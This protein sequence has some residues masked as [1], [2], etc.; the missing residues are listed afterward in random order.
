M[1]IYKQNGYSLLGYRTAD[2]EVVSSYGWESPAGGGDFVYNYVVNGVTKTS[3]VE[4]VAIGLDVDD[5]SYRTADLMGNDIINLQF[6]LPEFREFPTGCF[7]VFEGRTY[8]LFTTPEITRQHNRQFDYVMPMYTADYLLHLTLMRNV[9]TNYTTGVVDGDFRL[10]FTLTSYPAEHLQMIADCLNQVDSGWTVTVNADVENKEKLVPYEFIYCDEALRSIAEAYDTEYEFVGKN[11]ILGKVEHNKNTPLSMS[12]GRGNGFKSGVTRRNESDKPPVDRLYIQGGEQNIPENY[13]RTPI[14][15]DENNKMTYRG[16]ASNLLLLPRL[17]TNLDNSGCPTAN[18]EYKGVACI[19]DGSSFYFILNPTVVTD[20]TTHER[21]IRAKDLSDTGEGGRMHIPDVIYDSNGNAIDYFL[22]VPSQCFLVSDDGRSVERVRYANHSDEVHNGLDP[23][24]RPRTTKVEAVYDASEV[25]PMRVGGVSKAQA[26]S[27][28]TDDD[29]NSITFYDIYDAAPDCPNY[30]D[31]SIQT[32]TMTIIFQDGMLAGR[33]FDLN[34]YDSGQYKDLPVCE[35]TTVNGVACKRLELCQAEQDGMPM[36]GGVFIPRYGDHYIIFHCSLPKEYIGSSVGDSS[37]H[38]NGAQ[39]IAYGA[40]FRALREAV[41]YLYHHGKATF[42]FSGSVDTMWV[43]KKWDEYVE[44]YTDVN[45]PHSTY[46]ALGQHI[47]VMDVQFFCARGLVM[48]VTG[49]KQPINNPHALEMTLTNALTLK[50]NWV[51]QLTQTVMDVRRRPP[52][53]RPNQYAFPRNFHN[54]AARMAEFSPESVRR[55]RWARLLGIASQGHVDLIDLAEEQ[56]RTKVNEVIDSLT[57]IQRFVNQARL[58]CNQMR[59]LIA[60][61]SG[62]P[63]VTY[64]TYTHAITGIPEVGDGGG[65]CVP[66][67]GCSVPISDVRVPSKLVI[68]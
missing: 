3:S 30:R 46:F 13:G 36:P 64:D 34:C 45:I 43:K 32:E 5:D 25:Y 23:D 68:E 61:N 28:G 62:W 2:G 37:W 29:G 6:S 57:N 49:I 19:Y 52:F 4:P 56:D 59:E 20:Q 35:S 18:S 38:Y 51:S 31:C 10:K 17:L 66:D 1:V 15:L 26:V 60:K 42:T 65:Y 41:H 9:V 63:G 58:S 39:G 24:Y 47:K 16:D 8:Y 27:G 14:G 33:E 12:Y 40:E 54:I 48:R 22:M 7:A 50:F 55:G 67:V 53:L 21:Y 11:I 44:Q